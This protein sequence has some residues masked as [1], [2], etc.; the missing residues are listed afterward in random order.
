MFVSNII[1]TYTKKLFIIYLKFS[2][3]KLPVFYLATLPPENWGKSQSHGSGT[4][5]QSGDLNSDL[6]SAE[7]PLN[8]GKGSEGF[9]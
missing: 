6:R 9:F 5:I 8:K 7:K 4:L 2:F 1:W 3:T